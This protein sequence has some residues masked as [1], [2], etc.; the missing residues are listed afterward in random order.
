MSEVA[1]TIDVT[2]VECASCLDVIYSRA[3][4]D[5]RRCSCGAT[6]VD[7]GPGVGRY[8]FKGIEPRKLVLEVLGTKKDLYDDWNHRGDKYGLLKK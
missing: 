4:H 1:K 6:F 2:A 5:F 3:N 7:G 8:G